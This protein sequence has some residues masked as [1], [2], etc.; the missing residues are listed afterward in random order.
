[1]DERTRNAHVRIF[2][3]RGSLHVKE[4]VRAE[5]KLISILE[6]ETFGASNSFFL[7]SHR[8][9]VGVIPC[10]VIY[11]IVEHILPHLHNVYMLPPLSSL[12]EITIF[13]IIAS[14]PTKAAHHA[15]SHL[16]PSAVLFR[17]LPITLIIIMTRKSRKQD[18]YCSRFPIMIFAKN[19][20]KA[21][22]SLSNL[23]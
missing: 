18:I 2:H 5:L 6:W 9:L 22:A 3:K 15:L 21:S 23:T 14:F 16:L 17:T 12:S 11:Y 7:F 13:L 4:D 20:L 8:R 19:T 1:M 10:M